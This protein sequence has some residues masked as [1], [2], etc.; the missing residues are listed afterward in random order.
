MYIY[1]LTDDSGTFIGSSKGY[2]DVSDPRYV[3]QLNKMKSPTMEVIRD[4]VATSDDAELEVFNEC[5]NEILEKET[6]DLLNG[7]QQR[8][9]S[10]MEYMGRHFVIIVDCLTKRK[11]Y[12][13]STYNPVD[14]LYRIFVNHRGRAE[15]IADLDELGK[16]AFTV[17]VVSTFDN[18]YREML[19]RF[20]AYADRGYAFYNEGTYRSLRTASKVVG[21]LDG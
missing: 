12:I 10:I 1:R 17:D 3:K 8:V 20:D 21:K 16:G 13:K 18:P 15:L 9:D 4:D 6:Y 2:P 5:I 11:A 19:R 7:R 14:K